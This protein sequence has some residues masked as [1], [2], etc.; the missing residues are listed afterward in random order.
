[1]PL[2]DH[3]VWLYEFPFDTTRALANLAY[4]GTLE[5][6]PAI[7]LQLAHLGGAAP[8]LAHRLAARPRLPGRG[9]AR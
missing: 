2:A 6:W 1:L 4:S 8:F 7:R 9:C 5:R 3:P